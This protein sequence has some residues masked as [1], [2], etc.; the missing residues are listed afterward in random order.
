MTYSES[1]Y[2]EF[3][4]QL[5]IADYKR[6]KMNRRLTLVGLIS[7]LSLS[8]LPSYAD[9]DG[10]ISTPQKVNTESCGS[11]GVTEC[12]SGPGSSLDRQKELKK[13]FDNLKD[14]TFNFGCTRQDSSA[15]EE[16]V[17]NSEHSKKQNMVK[18]KESE[19]E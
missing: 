13:W 15:S 4:F 16:E 14:K 17:H 3:L 5:Y 9:Q 1:Y 2:I 18:D 6:T 12:G 7:L 10:L 19:R 8:I 11:D